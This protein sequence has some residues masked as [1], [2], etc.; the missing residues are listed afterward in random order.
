MFRPA[1]LTFL[2]LPTV[3][4][5]D[6]ETFLLAPPDTSS[7]YNTFRTF[8]DG[9]D[10]IYAWIEARDG[11]VTDEEDYHIRATADRTF[12]CLD[13]TEEA[14]FVREYRAGEA[15]VCIKEVLD[16]LPA[17]LARTIPGG[18][19]WGDEE[20]P[21]RWTIPNTSMAIVKI[22][23]GPRAGEYL[24]S[25]GTVENAADYYERVAHLPYR[26]QN[27][28]EGF[29]KWFVSMPRQAWLSRIV[30]A[31]PDWFLYRVLGQAVWQW[32][33]LALLLGSAGLLV[34]GIYWFVGQRVAE[35]REG[36][37]LRFWITLWAPIAVLLVP[38]GVDHVLRVYLVISGATL[39]A[40][41]FVVD[42]LILVALV[43]LVMGINTRIIETIVTSRRLKPRGLDEQLVR[44]VGRLVG[45]VVAV[46]VFLEGGQYLGI[47]LTT[48]LAGA[49]VGG[50]ALAL[51]AQ[52]M[53]KNLFGSL[54]ILFDK[55]F[56]LGERI[57][58][59]GYDGVVEEIGLRSTRIRTLTGHQV[60]IPNE[61]MARVDIENI[62]R[63][64]HIRRLTSLRLP[65]DTPPDK[66]NEAVEIVRDVLA[67]HEGMAED[68]P[69]RVFLDEFNADS[70]SLRFF[71]W[72]HPPDYWAF[73]EF[74]QRVNLEIKERFA[75]AGLD[76]A[77]PSSTMHIERDEEFPT[78]ET[79]PEPSN[80]E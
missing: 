49:G 3:A 66:A 35:F 12:L 64:R 73:L 14:E 13:L 11:L 80:E 6:E 74:S 20:L 46:I 24:F 77:L 61:Q 58:A 39:L 38:I 70:L 19:G 57:V 5:A 69:P 4:C 31:L 44:L 27:S 45:I 54:M 10:E 68:F 72:Y 8:V 75:M 28:S 34:Y 23:E 2:L 51:A 36:N 7:P 59:H 30:L 52:D 32:I 16:R 65:L 67:D 53:L 33:G 9:C 29:Y 60:T 21:D 40:V 22:E 50:V 71:Y 62:G 43:M 76:F 63:R 41:R 48:L 47:P 79:L 42:L 56:R 15:T 1:L 25:K 17:I 26:N 55:P 37:L 78:G 18:P